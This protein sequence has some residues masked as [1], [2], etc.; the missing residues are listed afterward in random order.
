MLNRWV[1]NY[2]EAG[3]DPRDGLG[4][5]HVPCAVTDELYGD[6]VR[7]SSCTTAV[8]SAMTT[9]PAGVTVTT[10]WYYIATEDAP[11]APW[12]PWP[13]AHESATPTDGR[14]GLRGTAQQSTAVRP[15]LKDLLLTD[16]RRFTADVPRREHDRHREIELT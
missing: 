1:Q 4:A 2:A 14:H 12:A 3:S 11:G 9:A 7:F 13:A 6:E 15:S 8:K 16:G 10:T 5:W